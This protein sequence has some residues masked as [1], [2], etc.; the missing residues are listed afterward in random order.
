MYKSIP[1]SVPSQGVQ[2]PKNEIKTRRVDQ[3]PV[4]A[5]CQGGDENKS[6]H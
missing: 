4:L 6:S 3:V 5:T 2:A 1:A